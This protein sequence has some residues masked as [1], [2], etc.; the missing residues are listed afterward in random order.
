MVKPWWFWLVPLTGVVIAYKV[1]FAIPQIIGADGYLHWRM[2]RLVAEKGWLRSL[3]QAKYSLWVEKF[4]DK[5][6]VYHLYLLLFPSVKAGAFAAMAGLVVVFA[7]VA[8]SW[9]GPKWA[10][11]AI[12]LLFLSAQ[13]WRDVAEPRPVVLA[14]TLNLLGIW[15]ML[16]RRGGWLGVVSWAYGITHLSSYLLLAAVFL[17]LI[18]EV[19]E[20][21]KAVG[22]ALVYPLIGWLVSFLTHPSFPNNLFYFYLNGIMVPIYAART[23]V[24]ELGAEFFPLHTQQLLRYFPILVI[25]GA[26]TVWLLLYQHKTSFPVRLRWL[27]LVA[28]MYGFLGL[29]ARKNLTLGYPVFLLWLVGVWRQAAK[30]VGKRVNLVGGLVGVG[31]VGVIYATVQTYR[32]LEQFLVAER[33]YGVHFEAVGRWL[34]HNVSAGETVFHANWSDAQYL[35]G[36]DPAHNF[37]VTLDPIYMYAWNKDLYAK[38][39]QVALGRS[40]TPAEDLRQYFQARYGYAGKNYFGGLINQV[41]ADKD[42]FVVMAEDDLGVIFL[43]KREE[44]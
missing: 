35:I 34:G 15:L 36:L 32:N 24:L 9:W 10:I 43:V 20:E 22:R 29:V 25:G 13:F 12:M 33:A 7:L 44:E 27:F 17:W 4:A 3:P 8:R 18:V 40:A 14:I 41:K 2:S 11:L 28:M 30:A 26:V 21:R 37:L 23:G 16:K 42:N 39:R 5:D 19:M 6:F 38:Y 31:M 1:Q